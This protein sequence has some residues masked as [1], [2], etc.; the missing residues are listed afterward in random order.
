[1]QCYYFANQAEEEGWPDMTKGHVLARA[2]NVSSPS[3]DKWTICIQIG[4]WLSEGGGGGV[5]GGATVEHD[6]HKINNYRIR[7]RYWP[8]GPFLTVYCIY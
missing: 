5:G 6:K 8:T 3:I 4:L 1:V 2:P 7:L